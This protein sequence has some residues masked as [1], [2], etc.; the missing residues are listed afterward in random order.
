MR[1]E[2]VRAGSWQS[3]ILCA[4]VATWACLVGGGGVERLHPCVQQVWGLA[5]SSLGCA[6]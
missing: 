4:I 5:D 6:H 2:D 3:H 1:L